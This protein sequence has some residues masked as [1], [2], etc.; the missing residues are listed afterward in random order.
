MSDSR[1]PRLVLDS[2]ICGVNAQCCMPEHSTLPTAA[3]VIRCYP[4][5]NS[6]EPLDCFSIDIKSA[7]KRIAV[8][9]EDRG[10]LGFQF[11]GKLFFDR[12]CPFGAVFSAHYWSRLAGALLRLW[13]RISW[14]SHA[15]FLYVDDFFMFQCAKMLPVSACMICA[16]NILCHVPI[17]WKKCEIGPCIRWIGWLF[18]V[19][20]GIV[21]I[22]ADKQEKLHQLV[23]KLLQSSQQSRKTLEKFLGLAMWVTQLYPHLR[24][25]LHWVYRDL[26]SIPASHYSV[27]PGSW[28]Q[29]ISSLSPDLIF[30]SRPPHTAIPLHSRLI[31]VRHQEVS[32]KADLA[33]CR[34]GDKR[35]WLR[36]RDPASSK[37]KLSVES[38]KTIRLFDK[39]ITNLCPFRSMWPKPF[40]SGL[41][42][43][44][45]F[46][47]GSECGIGGI[48]YSPAGSTH[49]FSLRLHKADF[50]ALEIPL[51]DDLQKDIS[52]LETLAQMALVFM[53]I[54][55]HPGFRIPIR[56]STLSD[57]TAAESSSNRLFSTSMPLALFLEK[58]SLLISKSSVEVSTSHI[59]G[60]DN[61]VADKLSRWDGS[62]SPA[63]SSSRCL[64]P[65]VL[66]EL[67][68]TSVAG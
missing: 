49:W 44:D 48:I 60:H 57:N 58:L 14:L 19:R 31:S 68:S 61:D 2:S 24:T 65:M 27:D 7:H 53:V 41:C 3:D 62:V 66:S 13:R 40:W 36:I 8:A 56:I 5:R 23:Q 34:I 17:S 20:T 50:E 12:V 42:V 6:Q 22:P 32:S 67:I 4:L 43:A 39:W 37:R 35:I 30:E 29:V 45:A 52:S 16:L 47:H 54:R 9:A 1:P 15:S 26:Y 18:D 38:T 64:D 28:N 11:R 10:F 55:M 51:H 63:I 46:A 33:H 25:W 59:A 21:Y